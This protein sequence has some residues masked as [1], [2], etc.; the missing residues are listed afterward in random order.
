HIPTLQTATLAD[1]PDLSPSLAAQD[2][3][4]Y[5]DLL[6]HD[7]GDD[8]KD[9]IATEAAT[10]SEWRT[11]PLWGL[12]NKKFFLHDGRTTDIDT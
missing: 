2:A 6:L 12:S 5:S 10:G 4:L 7:M 8:L 3:N 1:N 11:Q 9:G